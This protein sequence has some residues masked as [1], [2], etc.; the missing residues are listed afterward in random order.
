MDISLLILFIFFRRFQF[1]LERNVTQCAEEEFLCVPSPSRFWARSTY[2]EWTAYTFPQYVPALLCFKPA[3]CCHKLLDHP[4]VSPTFSDRPDY[5]HPQCLV[6]GLV[7]LHVYQP[8]TCILT[9]GVE[10]GNSEEWANKNKKATKPPVDISR[11]SFIR[12]SL[13]FDHGIRPCPNRW[14][15]PSFDKEETSLMMYNCR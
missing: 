1:L 6:W 11:F 7:L 5:G 4:H 13:I 12:T 3:M 15:S 8:R 2:F 10:I 9:T 14:Y